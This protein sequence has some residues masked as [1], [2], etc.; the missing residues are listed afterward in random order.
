MIQIHIPPAIHLDVAEVV[1]NWKEKGA[2]ELEMA[3]AMKEWKAGG[4][5]QKSFP[6]EFYLQ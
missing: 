5:Q 2:I 6:V 3:Q 1:L 4:K